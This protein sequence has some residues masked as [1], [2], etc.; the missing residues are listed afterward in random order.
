MIVCYN[1]AIH[2][3]SSDAAPNMLENGLVKCPGDSGDALTLLLHHQQ[4]LCERTDL[5][6]FGNYIHSVFETLW[7]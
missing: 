1:Q 4:A 2:C 3:P 7:D 5:Q 6:Q